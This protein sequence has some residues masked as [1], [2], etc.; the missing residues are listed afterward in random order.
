VSSS[1]A[2]PPPSV[3]VMLSS[4]QALGEQEKPSCFIWDGSHKGIVHCEI[5]SGQQTSVA[6]LFRCHMAP[7]SDYQ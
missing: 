3:A 2:P 4:Q 6:S 7:K 5:G 1:Q